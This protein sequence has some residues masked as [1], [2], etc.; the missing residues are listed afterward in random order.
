M[1][2]AIPIQ[3]QL[4]IFRSLFKGR[5]DCYGAESG[6]V[7]AQLTDSVIT[8]HL[9]GQRRIGV[10]MLLVDLT[11]FA[12]ID[13]DREDREPIAVE[14]T[15]E[16][17]N[18]SQTYGLSGYVERSKRKGYHIWY[19]FSDL[20][21]ASK[22]RAILKEIHS[23]SGI[24]E[25]V[26]IFPKQNH[27]KDG[28]YGNFVNLPLFKPDLVNGKTAFLDPLSWTPYPDQFQFLTNL[29][30]IT[31]KEIDD[32]IEINNTSIIP[33]P[34]QKTNTPKTT[35]IEGDTSKV[36]AGCLFIQH[37][38]NEADKL[39]EPLWYA[40]I[41]NLVSLP[42]GYEKI[43]EFS[44]PYKRYTYNE[45]QA[46][47][48][49]AINDAPGPTTCQ[50]IQELG[51]TCGKV[52]NV[53]APAGLAYKASKAGDPGAEKM[54]AEPVTYNE[55]TTE[56]EPFPKTD[57]TWF[58]KYL[59]LF[60]GVTEAP[61]SYHFL[62][63]ASAV[64]MLLNRMIHFRY[65]HNLYPN[66]FILLVGRSGRERKDT[67]MR[68]VRNII[69]KTSSC[70]IL[71]S[72]AS[73]EGLLQAMTKP[74]AD[75]I[76]G[77]EYN[78]AICILSEFNAL[79]KKA[80]NDSISNLIPE[81]CGLYDMPNKLNLLTRGNPLKIENPFFSILAGIQPG[82]LTKEMQSGDIHG[83]FTGR[84]LYVRGI[85]KDPVA[86]PAEI[87]QVSWNEITG[88]LKELNTEWES[89][90]KDGSVKLE[91]TE[92]S[93]Q[94]W[95]EFYQWHFTKKGEVSELMA[96][97][98]ERIP[99]QV[100]KLAL[101]FSA[102]EGFYKIEDYILLDAIKVGKWCMV[103]T[104]NLFQDFGQT[105]REKAENKITNMLKMGEMSRRKLQ[106]NSNIDAETFSHAMLN[107]I[108]AGLVEEIR[109]GKKK[110]V[111][112]TND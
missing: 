44:E 88:H 70:Q 67:A 24:S 92:E 68:F 58:N 107:L 99:E 79:L 108:S 82:I 105:L 47:I 100:L 89:R 106:Q 35:G 3:T 20:V 83:G 13:V 75:L 27:V 87:D 32:I 63:F 11:H 43:H 25:P 59:S 38:I 96:T 36:I 15:K 71:S 10:Y 74:E 41:C 57:Q 49:H 18:I 28:E 30:K 4:N 93:K 29:K 19:F 61:E 22:V 5:S 16:I 102:I 69:E 26:E 84:F 66:L 73:Y 42:G 60:H 56:I 91:W 1:V 46:K 80:R 101:I 23:G 34:V 81:L 95:Q 21:Q 8:Q 77:I 65:V 78:K 98:V 50:Q 103:N 12:C 110:T 45:T 40:M 94:V 72:L 90:S 85:A 31:P 7:K 6:N 97:L 17:L 52:C 48:E 51:F 62:G 109:N 111:K 37:C 104:E 55:D 112:L 9:L 86:I 54:E 64:G 14:D 39:P 33:E 76:D 2:L 53:K